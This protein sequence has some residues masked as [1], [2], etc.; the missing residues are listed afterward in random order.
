[1]NVPRR[2]RALKAW[3]LS[4]ALAAFGVCIYA[5]EQRG[6]EA[7]AVP[8]E[9]AAASPVQGSPIAIVPLDRANGGA[10]VTG[11]LEVTAGRAIITSSGTV[12]SG[13]HTTDV[14]LPHRG[15]LRISRRTTPPLPL[16]SVT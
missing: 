5:Q 4:A 1:M 3:L 11:A 12:T 7:A 10:T 16:T 9:S 15:T 6:A 13:S 8:E 2:V 14:S